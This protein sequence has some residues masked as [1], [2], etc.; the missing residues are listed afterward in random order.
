MHF[1]RVPGG[2]PGGERHHGRMSD[3][4]AAR[5]ASSQ[6][7]IAPDT[8]DWTWVLQRPCPDCGF[9]TKDYPGVTV[10]AVL[11]AA[12]ER[13]SNLLARPGIADRPAPGVWSPLEYICHVRD[14]CV[15]ITGRR[16]GCWPRTTPS[17]PCGTRTR[18]RCRA[19]TPSRTRPSSTT[20]WP[21][22]PTRPVRCSPGC[23]PEQWSRPGHRSDGVA[24]TVETLAQYLVHEVQHHL[25][26]VGA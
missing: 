9:D 8:K 19:A 20:S 2:A 1:G 26:D 3:D 22:P 13:W 7:P 11:H 12:N 10:P 4:V 25:H 17:C 16:G 24:F 21:T 6:T 18:R 14:V 23:G 5:P 15:M